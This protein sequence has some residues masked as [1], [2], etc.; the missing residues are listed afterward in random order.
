MTSNKINTYLKLP[1]RRDEKWRYSDLKLLEIP[2]IKASELIREYTFLTEDENF[3]YIVLLN[4]KFSKEKSILPKKGVEISCSKDKIA[5]FNKELGFEDKYQ[6]SQNLDNNDHVV[7]ININDNIDKP[8]KLIKLI[9]SNSTFFTTFI[10][11]ENNCSV[12]FYE[13][14][15]QHG[16]HDNFINNVTR[17]NLS[18][19]T[20]CQHVIQKD[21]E[22]DVSFIN[23]LEII[24]NAYSIYE[25]YSVN[26]VDRSYRFE[27]EVHLNGKGAKASFYGVNIANNNQ[28][29]DIVIDVKHNASN[30]F[31]NQHYNQVL[32]KNSS[33]SFYSNVE[34]SELVSKV[35]AHQLN[36]NLLI[37]E[38]SV[39]YSRP[40][41]DINSDDVICSHGSTTGNID[42]EVLY[43]FAS[44][45]IKLKYAKK[46]IIIGLLK[47]VFLNCKLDALEVEGLYRRIVNNTEFYE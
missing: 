41:L 46:L 8:V 17:I 31:S 21:F 14:F 10:R 26:A 19:N 9:T 22:G 4:G 7:F 43:Y 15:I 12:K 35:E 27:S 30:T 18:D 28:A 2:D 45:G 11:L 3:Y 5:N 39:V 32:D 20:N 16:E 29:Y 36:K 44:R 37:D 40:M 38:K 33:G 24:C 6:V 42:K 47:S 34:I 23:T 13:D 25:N 1:S